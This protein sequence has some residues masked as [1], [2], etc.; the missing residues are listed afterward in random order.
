[1]KLES[2]GVLSYQFLVWGVGAGVCRFF[3]LLDLSSVPGMMTSCSSFSIPCKDLKGQ[4][5]RPGGQGENLLNSV[6]FSA[7]DI[8]FNS[9]QLN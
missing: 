3:S 8:Q 1:M 9:F 4:A 2:E 7:Y 5:R 6:H